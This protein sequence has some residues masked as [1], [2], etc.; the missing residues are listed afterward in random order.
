MRLQCQR[1]CHCIHSC[2]GRSHYF[3][4][5]DIQNTGEVSQKLRTLR[6]QS[7][8]Q[9]SALSISSTTAQLHLSL[10]AESS[11]RQLTGA[12]NASFCFSSRTYDGIG[13]AGSTRSAPFFEWRLKTMM[14]IFIFRC[15]CLCCAL[16][17]CGE[18]VA[19]GFAAYHYPAELGLV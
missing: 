7:Q 14:L 19:V 3:N 5:H 9:A 16:Q 4:C 12:H 1:V 17:W 18:D 2:S 11:T 10:S 15:W 13:I 8:H 6:D